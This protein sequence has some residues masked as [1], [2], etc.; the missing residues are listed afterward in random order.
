MELL[1]AMLHNMNQSLI[2]MNFYFTATNKAYK[3]KVNTKDRIHQFLYRFSVNEKELNGM[4]IFGVSFNEQKLD[5]ENSLNDIGIKEG[6]TLMVDSIIPTKENEK[7]FETKDYIIKPYPETCPGLLIGIYEGQLKN[8]Q[9]D[10]KGRF[11]HIL[12]GLYDGEWKEGKKEGKGIDKMINIATNQ[13]YEGEF[14]DDKR[15]GKGKLTLG[16][17]EEYEGDWVNDKKE[18]KGKTIYPNG[19]IY[20]GDYKNGLGNG[21]GIIKWI[22][23]NE[24]EGEIKDDLMDGKGVFRFANGDSYEGEYKKDKKNGKGI[25]KFNGGDIYEGEFSNDKFNGKG[26]YKYKDGRYYEGEFLNEKINGKGKFKYSNGDTYEGEFMN[27]T[28][29]GFGKKTYT[30]GRVEEGLFE[31]DE[32]VKDY[33]TDYKY[34]IECIKTIDAKNGSINKLLKLKDGRL[35]SCSDDALNIYNKESYELELSIKEHTDKINSCIQLNDG[36]LVSCSKDKT[37]QIIELINEKEYK[38]TSTLKSD[39]SILDVIEIKNN[40]IISLSENIMQIWDLNTFQKIKTIENESNYILKINENEFVTSSFKNKIIKFWNGNYENIKTIDGI[41]VY[42]FGTTMDLYDNET[43][44]ALSLSH[45]YAIDIKKYEIISN[46][47]IT[48]RFVTMSKCL[49][50]NII[51]SINN[52]NKNNHIVKYNYDKKNL[53][54]IFEKKKAH[55]NPI[56]NC[57]EIKEGII[58][59]SGNEIKIWEIKEKAK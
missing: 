51:C 25:L 4:V 22:N 48:G 49:D 23:G 27:D 28:M 6:D 14:K 57:I 32:F 26:I 5:I 18:G 21:K 9:P 54:K 10:G 36:K 42:K 44:I 50:G 40:E 2:E 29:D 52:Y 16:D 41:Q 43:L 53:T 12:G 31:A 15:N 3:I 7:D 1:L 13:V 46:I 20:E 30:D 37:L 11:F 38:I 33:N 59:S 34:I 56:F 8:G 55:E 19:D 47:E 45:F 24:Y 17:G 39:A 58:A 35:L